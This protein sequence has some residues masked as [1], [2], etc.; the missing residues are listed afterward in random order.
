MDPGRARCAG[1][2]G[3][4]GPGPGPPER[5]RERGPSDPGGRRHV[6]A[7]ALRPRHGPEPGGGPG[8][9]R[10]RRRDRHFVVPHR[11]PRRG[12]T[13]RGLHRDR[14][15]LLR[16][17]ARSVG[18]RGGRP[19]TGHLAGPTGG[20]HPTDGRAGRAV[21][22]LGGGAEPGHPGSSTD[23]GDRRPQRPGAPIRWVRR[24]ARLGPP[25]H[26]V[27][28]HRVVRHRGLRRQ[29]DPPDGNAPALWR[30]GAAQLPAAERGAPDQ[31]GAQPCRQRRHPGPRRR[32]GDDQREDRRRH[33]RELGQGARPLLDSG[34]DSSRRRRRDG[35]RHLDHASS[36]RA[37]RVGRATSRSPRIR[38]PS[39]PSRTGSSPRSPSRRKEGS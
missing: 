9:R 30:P 12:P 21:P 34:R 13:S 29:P 7:G 15:R 38:G 6:R 17:P 8:R 19:G 23:R 1:R 24:S 11:T 28:G 36:R 25:G 10:G 18:H 35:A 26:G 39:A 31:P 22:L 2:T 27:G 37:H 33:R 16:A 20:A 32:G 14:V 3:G 4:R 5:R